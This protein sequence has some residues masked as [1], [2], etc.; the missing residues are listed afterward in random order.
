MNNL[1]LG[2][3]VCV[4]VTGVSNSLLEAISYCPPHVVK[5]A[6]ELI[7]EVP[8]QAVQTELVESVIRLAQILICKSLLLPSKSNNKPIFYYN[9]IAC[10]RKATI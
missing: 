2:M 6:P 9:E 10:S 3:R 5:I 4:N 7:A 1:K 8:A